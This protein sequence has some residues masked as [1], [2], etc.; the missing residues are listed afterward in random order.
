MTR[1]R[2]P[3]SMTALRVFDATDL[4]RFDDGQVQPL[5]GVNFRIAKASCRRVDP[6][7]VENP[8]LQNWCPR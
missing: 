5:R 1:S 4:K 7:G 3:R 8:L 2:T 6:R